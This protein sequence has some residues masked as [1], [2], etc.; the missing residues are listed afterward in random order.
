MKS[1]EKLLEIWGN[2]EKTTKD[3]WIY[4]MLVPTEKARLFDLLLIKQ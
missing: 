1:D 3:F 4:N 2:K